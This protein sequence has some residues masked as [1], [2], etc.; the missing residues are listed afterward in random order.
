MP[1]T[2]QAR[3]AASRALA[4]Y[5]SVPGFT[6]VDAAEAIRDLMTDLAFL[7]DTLKGDDEQSGR[8]ALEKALEVYEIEAAPVVRTVVNNLQMD[9]ETGEITGN[10][11][12]REVW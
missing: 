1:N 3:Q 12:S 6:E 5:R 9:V 8:Y 2:G 10:V 4:E 7:S 11:I